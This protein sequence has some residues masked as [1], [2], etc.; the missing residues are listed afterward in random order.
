MQS[1]GFETEAYAIL[2]TL[3]YIRQEVSTLAVGAAFG[4]AA[5]L[6][7]SGAKGKRAALPNA[8]IKLSPPRL[9]QAA[10]RATNVMIAANEMDACYET[11][12]DFMHGFTG[13]DVETLLA[14]LGRDLYMTPAE[15]IEYG[16]IDRIV[17]PTD[18]VAMEAQNYEAILRA[19]Q[20][21]RA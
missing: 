5:L 9:N 11:Y 13:R 17:R 16:L 10:G 15:A 1:V 6:L 2:D 20:G 4:N 14:E 12:V 8:R 21:A 18:Q 19:Q 7:G 3:N